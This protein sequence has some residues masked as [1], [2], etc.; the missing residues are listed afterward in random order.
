VAKGIAVAFL[1]LSVTL[2]GLAIYQT[3]R[4][5]AIHGPG[6]LAVMADDTVWIGMDASLEHVSAAGHEIEA[7][8]LSALGLTV[9]PA[10]LSEPLVGPV[11][12]MGYI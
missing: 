4:A 8:P 7:C 3:S 9:S 6:A 1:A 11:E 2:T 10:D 5:H 12:G